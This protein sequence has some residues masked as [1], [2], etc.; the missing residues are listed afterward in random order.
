M[1]PGP[2]VSI[3]HLNMRQAT[4]NDIIDRGFIITAYITNQKHEAFKMFLE[5]RPE[6]KPVAVFVTI[7]YLENYD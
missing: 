4:V 7:Q 2:V 1:I 5:S 3:T 6:E